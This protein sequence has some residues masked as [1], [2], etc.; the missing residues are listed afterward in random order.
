MNPTRILS[1]YVLAFLA[2]TVA[3]GMTQSVLAQS[4]ASDRP[5]MCNG[6]QPKSSNKSILSVR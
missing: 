6:R 4:A 2:C 1:T 3:I 5:P